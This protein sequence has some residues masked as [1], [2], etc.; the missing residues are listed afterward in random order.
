MRCI[1]C[2][3]LLVQYAEDEDGSETE[4]EELRISYR[5]SYNKTDTAPI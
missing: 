2:L 3:L 5:V 4:N 1:M